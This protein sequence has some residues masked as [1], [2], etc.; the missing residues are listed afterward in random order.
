MSTAETPN[1]DQAKESV[2]R[3]WT[4][5]AAGWRKRSARHVET[6]REAT[7]AIVEAAQVR[8]GMRVLD[9]ASGTGEPCLTL[10]ERVGPD[11]HVTATDLVPEMLAVAEENA[12]VRGQTNISFQ[13]ADAEA[14]PFAD[15]TFD[16]VTCRFGV[17]FFA[18][19]ERALREVY[20]VLEPGGRV[21]LVAWGPLEDNPCFAIVEGAAAKYVHGPLSTRHKYGQ[22]GQL[23]AALREAGFQQVQEERRAIAWPIPGSPEQAWEGG[24]EQN[25]T[26]RR[27]AEQLTPEQLAQ[28]RD[29]VLA[30][31]RQY[32]DGE[33]VRF[34]GVIM[35][36]TGVR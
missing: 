28:V 26:L 15:Q 9:L 22:A 5:N 24:R 30:T 7:E 13:Q 12:R 21:A 2:R 25:S 1:T 27:L 34:P 19:V 11:G 33:Q 36:A 10:A 35:V 31:S 3:E 4:A 32:Y 23:A 20:R 6:S 18:D 16:A 17:M 29:E 14:L 8:P